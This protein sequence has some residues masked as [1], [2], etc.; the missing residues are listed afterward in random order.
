MARNFFSYEVNLNPNANPFTMLAISPASAQDVVLG[1]V[2]LFP[3]GVSASGA[4]L[5]FVLWK[6]DNT[7]NL[8][9]DSARIRKVNRFSGPAVQSK[10][11]KNN[12]AGEPGVTET[13]YEARL[14][15]HEQVPGSM[16]PKNAYREFIIPAGEIWLVR[17]I[18]AQG[19]AVT[20]RINCEE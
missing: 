6:A 20:V 19:I 1:V 12:A 13:L 5:Q 16:L 11:Y 4:P 18:G 3:E 15:V 14:N 7:T 9:D 10:I 17:S 2:E 8:L